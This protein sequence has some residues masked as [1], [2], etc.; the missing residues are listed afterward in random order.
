MQIEATTKINYASY[1]KYYLFNFLQ[2]KRSPWQARLLLVLAP[3]L[4]AGFL[5]LYLKDPADI[6]N[7]I[8]TFI[9]F[10]LGIV[11]FSIVFIT[12]RSYYRS[13][14]KQI[15]IPFHYRFGDEQMEASQGESASHHVPGKD[16]KKGSAAE[17]NAPTAATRYEM[18]YRAFETK[19]FFYIYINRKQIYIIGKSDFTL[20]SAEEL[21]EF[22]KTRLR[23]RFQIV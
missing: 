16:N 4:F 1:R 10:F 14:K 11:L 15:E 18:I 13:V 2:G 21:R 3:L 23:V 19:G 7:L 8:G 5:Y 12:P 9:M 17:D 22:L 6:I 20:G